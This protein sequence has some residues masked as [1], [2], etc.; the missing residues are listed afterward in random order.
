MCYEIESL[1]GEA[2]RNCEE[3]SRL[4]GFSLRL[5]TGLNGTNI[6]Y[7][8][9]DEVIHMRPSNNG[10]VLLVDETGESMAAWAMHPEACAKPVVKSS[11]M[12]RTALG[13]DAGRI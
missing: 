7:V 9:V 10:F 2:A 5:G 4:W 6:C 13:A 11:L 8:F 1:S 12:Q 3:F